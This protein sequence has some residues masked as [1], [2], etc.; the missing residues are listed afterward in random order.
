[1]H[2]FKSLE[3]SQNPR[4]DSLKSVAQSSLTLPLQ[5]QQDILQS[6]AVTKPQS[7]TKSQAAQSMSKNGETTHTFQKR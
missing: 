2:M 5:I 4:C 1:M 6:P 7:M 3:N